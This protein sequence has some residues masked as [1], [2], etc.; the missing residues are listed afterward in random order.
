MLGWFNQ[1]NAG[2]IKGGSFPLAQRM[3]EKFEKLGGKILYK[4]K[5][6]KII[7]ENNT[8]KG[9]ILSDGTQIL[10]DYVISA[11]DGYTTIYKMLGGKYVS[12]KVDYAYKNWELFTPLVQVSFG[13]KK[14]VKSES[15]IISILQKIWRLDGQTLNTDIPL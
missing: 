11:A 10:S 6:E 2:Y 14:V 1:K 12:K 9:I 4:T 13:I 3:V 15:P 5:V 8:A 7:I